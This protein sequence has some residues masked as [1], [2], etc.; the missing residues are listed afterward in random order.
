M[1]KQALLLQQPLGS[2]L[3]LLREGLTI[4]VKPLWKHSYRHQEVC[5]PDHSKSVQVD[6]IKLGCSLLDESVNIFQSPCP[7]ETNIG[8]I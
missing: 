2:Q 5:F 6:K 7:K 8:V 4:V 1:N 3:L